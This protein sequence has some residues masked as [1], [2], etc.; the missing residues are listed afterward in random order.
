MTP[1]TVAIGAALVL[2]G[3]L[4]GLNVPMAEAQ[5]NGPYAFSATA[6]AYAWRMNVRTGQVSTCNGTPLGNPPPAPK[7]SPWGPVSR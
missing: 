2:V 1:K 5:R 7:C 3:V 4:V 6:P